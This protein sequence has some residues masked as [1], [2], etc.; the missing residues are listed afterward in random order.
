MILTGGHVF[1][2][3]LLVKLAILAL[4]FLAAV[5][6]GVVRP[7]RGLLNIWLLAV[8]YLAMD[9]LFLLLEAHIPLSDIAIAYNTYYAYLLIAPTVV[10]LGEKLSERWAVLFLSIIFLICWVV[11]T[12]Q[13]ITQQPLLYVASLEGNFEVLAWSADTGIRAFS[14]FSSGLGYGTICCLLGAIGVGVFVKSSHKLLAAGLF[15]LAAFGCY[16]T[17]TRNC[18]LQ[19]AF[20]ICT[21]LCL[22][23]KRLRRL[24]RYLPFVFLI[25]S[26][27]IAFQG[28]AADT[29]DSAV[30]SNLSLLIRVASWQY[31]AT[32]YAAAPV[33]ERIFGLG[34]VQN[35]NAATDT[36]FAV[37]N[38]FLAILLNAG[39][40]GFVLLFWLQWKMWIRL[41]TRALMQPS[42]FTFAVAGLWSTFLAVFFYNISLVPFCLIY[43]LAFLVK[44][45][46]TAPRRR[47]SLPLS[48]FGPKLN[49]LGL[50]PTAVAS[51][52][53]QLRPDISRFRI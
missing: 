10:F 36:L 12:A 34:I 16:T 20:T 42:A 29:S 48:R 38:Q 15:S 40:A 7:G 27:V 26:I 4:L 11:G 51:K 18:Y 30:S 28:I 22:A 41:Y 45:R 19:F 44:P 24:V 9:A 33:V 17:F 43:I 5:L 37:D 14:L 31:Y 35:S 21:I 53:L 49:Q 52:A 25:V 1:I 39:L 13:F 3:M 46:Q 8:L 2:P 32:L 6:S 23:S 50:R 47:Q